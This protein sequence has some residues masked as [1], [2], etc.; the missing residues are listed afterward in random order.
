VYTNGAW[1]ILR[2]GDG[3]NTVVGHGGSAWVPVPADYDG[4]EKADIAV[5]N[6]SGAW[7]I[8]QSSNNAINVVGHGGGPNDVPLK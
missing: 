2:S 5:Y 1:S 4:D 3:G 6:A 8:K 7:S